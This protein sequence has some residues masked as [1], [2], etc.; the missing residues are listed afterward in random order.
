MISYLLISSD[1]IR[2]I[3]YD[4]SWTHKDQI[5]IISFVVDNL[6]ENFRSHDVSLLKFILTGSVI[7]ETTWNWN[8]LVTYRNLRSR[9]RSVMMSATIQKDKFDDAAAGSTSVRHR[10]YISVSVNWQTVSSTTYMTNHLCLL[11][12]FHSVIINFL[13]SWRRDQCLQSSLTTSRQVDIIIFPFRPSQRWTYSIKFQSYSEF[14]HC[15]E[16]SSIE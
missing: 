14:L 6:S 3:R 7:G 13:K 9:L 5:I 8:C 10:R 1:R 11:R 2:L 4:T 12:T 16:I 15:P